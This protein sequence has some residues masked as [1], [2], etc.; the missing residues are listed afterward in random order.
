MAGSCR[1]EDS[2]EAMP[3]GSRVGCRAQPLRRPTLSTMG[4]PWRRGL[5]GQA[6]YPG[7]G[8]DALEW[9]RKRIP[10]AGSSAVEWASTA[11]ISRGRLEATPRNASGSAEAATGGV[12]LQ[13]RCELL[14]SSSAYVAERDLNLA[15][16][17]GDGGVGCLD[18]GVWGGPFS[19]QG[20]SVLG[21]VSADESIPTFSARLREHDMDA[22][23]PVPG[24]AVCGLHAVV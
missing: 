16:D 1:S 19:S 12:L 2:R 10:R 5:V 22:Q 6:D 9:G 21:R 15:V 20:G 17:R 8:A 23:C 4:G 18:G 11:S 3:G 14:R 7:T 24:R 13:R